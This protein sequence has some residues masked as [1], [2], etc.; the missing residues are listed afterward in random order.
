MYKYN[1]IRAVH[2]EI[3]DKCNASCPMCARNK[4][5][6]EVNQYL[7]LIEL[8]LDDIKKILPISLIHQL[9]KLFM[10]GN[11]GDPIIAKD[12]LEI[13][14]YLRL[15]NA[16]I[17]LSMNTNGSARNEKWWKELG[18]IL[19]NRGDVKFGIDGLANTHHIYRKGTNYHKIMKNA[20]SFIKGGGNAI[21]EF[22]VFEHNEHQIEAARA[23]AKEYGFSK[24]TVKKTGRFF[25]NEKMQTKG[26][27]EVLDKKGG[28]EYT[29]KP[30]K[31]ITYQNNSLQKEQYIIDQFGS[32]K[33]YLDKTPISCKTLKEKSVYI[34]A[35]GLVFPCCWTA[36]QMYLW[37]KKTWGGELKPMIEA[38]GGVDIINAKNIPL[39][40]IIDGKF[41][42]HIQQS[43][44]LNSIKE[45]KL[46]VCSKTC[47]TLFDQFK[48]Q[49]K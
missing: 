49:Y 33:Q 14:R 46:T 5:G 43:W 27:R 21:W 34:S 3:T 37:Y 26:F 44:G 42:S 2:L 36:N 16:D 31:N 47:G 18:A 41:F 7:P 45:G 13:F 17:K 30:P 8:S 11:Y 29:I 35:E 6:G 48:D 15:N 12:T 20:R 39:K 40:E 1:D 22:I 24:F 9:D 25:S 28:V 23:I 19:G 10:C 38:T 32:M 4:N